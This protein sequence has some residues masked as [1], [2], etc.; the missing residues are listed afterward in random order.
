LF[1]GAVGIPILASVAGG[2]GVVALGS[3]KVKDDLL[4]FGVDFMFE[5]GKGAEEQVAGVGHYRSATRRNL[6]LSLTKKEA[7]EEVVDGDGGL[8]FGETLGE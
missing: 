8:E 7:G 4:G 3:R 6:A 5:G 1:A 2:I